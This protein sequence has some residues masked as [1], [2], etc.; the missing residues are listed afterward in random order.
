MNLLPKFKKCPCCKSLIIFKLNGV[1]Y[2][3]AFQSL[4]TW[5]LKKK[6]NCKKCNVELALFINNLDDK[7]EKLLWIDLFK[8]ED[9]YYNELSK[10]QKNK[11]DFKKN[12]KKYHSTL[13]EI[14]SIQNKIRLEQAKVKIKL[15]I[16]NRLV[17]I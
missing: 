7:E 17:L 2:D 6:V 13:K 15:K 10:L 1:K 3:N 14:T 5:T 8:I 4:S 11:I 12:D 9:F 16:E